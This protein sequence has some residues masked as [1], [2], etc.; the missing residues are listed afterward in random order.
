MQ[1]Q[2][3]TELTLN[4]RGRKR[5]S[6]HRQPA[7]RPVPVKV[8]Y[9]AMAAKWPSR[10]DLPEPVRLAPEAETE[11]GKVY[12]RGQITDHQ[13][14]AG[15][16]YARIVSK[17]RAVIEG[18]NPSPT[19]IAGTQAAGGGLSYMDP[20]EA[21]SRKERYDGAFMA[22]FDAGQKAARAVARHAVYHH[23]L[24]HPDDLKYL[25]LGLSALATHFGLTGVRNYG[26]ST[27]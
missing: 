16:L 13:Y 4:R 20:A 27:H 7:G 1:P 12:L 25:R 19:S 11:F 15:M 21:V 2:G 14:R 3:T 6:G 17:Y 23:K 9:R 8:D 18:P 24:A 26:R 10:A 5:K 22:V